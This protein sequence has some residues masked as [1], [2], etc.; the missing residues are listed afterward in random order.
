VVVRFPPFSKCW[1]EMVGQI[2]SWLCGSRP[3][4]SAGQKW[5]DKFPRGGTI[6]ALSYVRAEMVEQIS[7]GPDPLWPPTTVWLFW[8]V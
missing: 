6:P 8:F 3:L 2:S 1:A 4:P 7:E 5:W